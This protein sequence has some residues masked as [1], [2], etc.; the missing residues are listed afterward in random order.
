MG[1]EQSLRGVTRPRRHWTQA[2]ASFLLAGSLGLPQSL[3]Q[4]EERTNSDLTARN[5]G[6]DGYSEA[7]EVIRQELGTHRVEPRAV[8]DFDA[9]RPEDAVIITHPEVHLDDDSLM[10]FLS[11]GGRLLILDDFGTSGPLLS[12]FQIQREPNHIRDARRYV[13]RNPALAV[14]SPATRPSDDGTWIRHPTTEGVREVITNHAVA[15]SHPE[16]TPL[17]EVETTQGKKTLAATGVIEGKGRL[18][19]IGDSSLFINLMLR[20][21]GN[22]RFLAQLA[23]YLVERDTDAQGGKLYLLSG[24]FEQK[25]TFG[26]S[27]PGEELAQR[28]RH[29]RE[30]LQR[31]RQEGLPGQM[32]TFL[33]ALL[34]LGLVGLELRGA[35]PDARVRTPSFVQSDSTR[36]SEPR[37]RAHEDALLLAELRSALELGLVSEMGRNMQPEAALEE[38]SPELR[39]TGKRLFSELLG[40]TSNR[41]PNGLTPTELSRLSSEV[42]TLIQ[43]LSRSSTRRSSPHG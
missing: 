30:E 40:L 34:A 28:L 29:L 42:L 18:V 2:W 33:A 11:E 15:L 19:A 37:D 1:K 21:P 6:W 31:I 36:T 9:L 32:A 8:L 3:A 4:G 17:L 5:S 16:L 10:R 27:R 12:R 7:L 41:P 22:R 43:H 39:E 13:A 26:Q 35:R 38:L 23:R 25:G 24:H 14:A 20:Y